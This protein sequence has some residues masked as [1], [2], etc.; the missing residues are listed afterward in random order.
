MW[1]SGSVFAGVQTMRTI[2]MRYICILITALLLLPAAAS[3]SNDSLSRPA[4]VNIQVNLDE[5]DQKYI[6][7]ILS[8]IESH[9]WITSVFVT[10]EFASRH[11]EAVSEIEK[12]GH[13]I[14]VYGWESNEDLSLL[15]Y[16]EQAVLIQKAISAV[17]EA[18]SN[19]KYVVDFKPQNLKYNDDTIK[20]LQ[21]IKMK[22]ITAAFSAN[23][24]FVQC[25]YAKCIGKVTFPYPVTTDFSAVPISDVKIGSEEVLLEDEKVFSRLDAHDYLNYLKE[26]YDEHNKTKDPMVIAVAPSITGADEAKLQVFSQFLDYIE[27]NG[28][29][30]GDNSIDIEDF[31]DLL[32]DVGYRAVFAE[33]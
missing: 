13:Y 16:N 8:E 27:E 15:N 11:P 20:A 17:R 30:N 12:R 7:K 23:E 9:G 1:V 32:Y 10:G 2:Y 18:V 28:N 14:G 4:A 22:S 24:S 33:V 6:H 29:V 25:P 21:D 5:E 19:P 31:T 3:A 26:E